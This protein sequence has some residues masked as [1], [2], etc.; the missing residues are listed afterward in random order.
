M[1][2]FSRNSRSL[3]SNWWWTVDKTLLGMVA[4]LMIL[5]IFLTFSA[6]PSVAQRV[7]QSSY[8]YIYR[9]CFFVPLAFVIMLF[10]SMQNL[11]FIRRFACLG[12]ITAILLT[13]M[14]LFWGEE[15][16][17]AHRWIRI[18]GFSLQ[19][20]EFI[21][22]TFAI[23]AA[24][25]FDAQK[26]YNE[27]PG[28][29]L[30]TVL[31]VATAGLLLSQPDIGMTFVVSAI[32]FFQ[33]FLN[34]L[35]IIWILGFGGLGICVFFVLYFTFPHFHIRIQQFLTSGQE[36]SY[37]VQKA[38]DAFQS[39]HY[40]GRGPGE[41]VA[42]LSI[43]DAHTDFIFAV[44]AEEFGFILCALLIGIYA[45]IV[46]RA[47]MISLKDKNYFIILSSAGLAASFG[48]QGIINMASSLHLM[49][50]KGMTLPF[51]S[52]GGSSVLASAI[53]IGMLLAITRKNA[54]S[55][56]KDDQ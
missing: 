21:K 3:L 47:M 8:H 20:S 46:I 45:T 16:K 41:G 48:L 42:K 35:P 22:P 19:P 50:T 55:E 40:L 9:Q 31:F 23:V 13:V 29:L 36:L 18:F 17:G 2:L 49:P 1:K 33:L 30:S 25:L 10:L 54:H 26:Q 11:K 34:G 32:W 53:G 51:I 38:M 12:Y 52:Y 27:I 14:T 6:S 44:A 24:W 5:G 7:G 37:Q 15:I 28:T 56:D 4:G 39:G 43:P